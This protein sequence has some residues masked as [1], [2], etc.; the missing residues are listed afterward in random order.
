MQVEWTEWPPKLGAR[1]FEIASAEPIQEEA[2]ASIQG[3]EKTRATATALRVNPQL[4]GVAK[5][6]TTT[7][8]KT[9]NKNLLMA[10]VRP[11]LQLLMVDRLTAKG[12]TRDKIKGP[13]APA[14][15]PTDE[16]LFED[17]ANPAQKFALP[18]YR[19]AEQTVGAKQQFRVKLAAES[20]GGTLTVYLEKFLAPAAAAGAELPHTFTVKLIARVPVG[21]SHVQQE[22]VFQETVAEGTLFKAVLRMSTLAQV[23]QVFQVLTDPS[24]AAR[25]VVSRAISSAWPVPVDAA[26][27]QRR[28][29]EI[30][31]MQ[32]EV[33]GLTSQSNAMA[34]QIKALQSGGMM[35]LK[36]AQIMALTKQRAA[37]E[38]QRTAKAA[39]LAKKQA[40]LQA[41]QNQKLFRVTPQTVDWD[42]SPSPFV[43]PK[44][45]HGYVFSDIVPNAGGRVGFT[46]HQVTWKERSHTYY[47]QS[48]DPFRVMFLPDCFK[49]ARRPETPHY[50]MLTVRFPDPDAPPDKMPVTL[51]YVAEPFVDGERLE[52]AAQELKRRLP[53]LAQGDRRIEFEPLL[54][55]SAK[56][57]LTLP[58]GASGP[59]REEQKDAQVD[60]RTRI[61]G[62]VTLAMPD[63]QGVYDAMFGDSTVV[64]QGTVTVTLD[65]GNGIPPENIPVTCRL[66]DLSGDVFDVEIQQDSA[67]NTV[68][69]KLTNAIES[70]VELRGLRAML[71][72]E[73]AREG[74]I[75]GLSFAA[76]VA[77]APGALVECRITAADLP[78]QGPIAAMMDLRNVMVKPEPEAVWAAIVSQTRVPEFRR[79]VT[80]KAIKQTFETGADPVIAMVID[81]ENGSSIDL[82]LEKLFADAEVRVPLTDLVLRRADTGSYRYMVTVIRASGQTKDTAWRSDRTGILFPSVAQ[83]VNG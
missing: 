7:P 33:T 60:V 82:S 54:C 75:E 30:Q 76:P 29:A 23:T 78:G 63:F 43:F 13:V 46:L 34:A 5:V 72:R 80:V 26:E 6:S 51:E 38:A 17:A 83:A 36:A 31:K 22:L 67:P 50:P 10:H 58:R 21:T 69:A 19:L 4:L 39:E 59:Q 64:F 68:R 62:A 15:N 61:A 42:V 16:M 65:A 49:V 11:N 27:V 47:Q 2:A 14:P 20:Q 48:L 41:V 70:P 18:R 81:F 12:V 55:E 66:N 28:T 44:E 74:V 9:V 25:L 73:E 35:M 37:I 77:V 40:D 24:F 45:L 8:V 79:V 32:Q 52:A 3:G 1:S 53:E 56:L 71:A 57:F